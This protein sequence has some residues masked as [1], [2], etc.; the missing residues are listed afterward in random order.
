MGRGEG[1]VSEFTVLQRTRVNP[2]NVVAHTVS[3][4]RR[5][6]QKGGSVSH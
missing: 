2:T 5:L 6:K 4:L 3:E 1:V